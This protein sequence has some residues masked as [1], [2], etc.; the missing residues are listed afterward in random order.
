MDNNAIFAAQ[1]AQYNRMY[2]GLDGSGGR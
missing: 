1:Q 2:V